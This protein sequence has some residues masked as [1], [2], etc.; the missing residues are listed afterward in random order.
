M[1]GHGRRRTWVA[2][3]VMVL[4]A[5]CGGQDAGTTATAEEDIRE[6][7]VGPEL[8]MCEGEGWHPC[9]VV[10]WDG[11]VLPQYMMEPIE[12][13]QHEEGVTSRLRVR[14]T[15]I[16]EPFEDASSIRFELVEVLES[17]R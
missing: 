7:E 9:M 3:T 16:P 1:M 12:G 8:E 2:A 10:H 17:S 6:V 5:G 14:L 4:A 13:F 15:P 11:D